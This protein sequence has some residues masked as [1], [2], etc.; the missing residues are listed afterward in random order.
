[1]QATKTMNV[2]LYGQI[3]SRAQFMFSEEIKPN[4]FQGQPMYSCSQGQIKDVSRSNNAVLKIR[5]CRFSV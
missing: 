2:V 1:M 5:L 3:K 4:A